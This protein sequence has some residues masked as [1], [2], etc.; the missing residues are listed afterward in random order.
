MGDVQHQGVLQMIELTKELWAA[1]GSKDVDAILE[2]LNKILEYALDEAD[3]DLVSRTIE[4]I[5]IIKEEN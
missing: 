1:T 5:Y 3:G 2:V 4:T